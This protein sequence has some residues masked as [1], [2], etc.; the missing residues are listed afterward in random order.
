MATKI[1]NHLCLTS[2]RDNVNV[3]TTPIS[4]CG[5]TFSPLNY[6]GNVLTMYGQAGGDQLIGG[7]GVDVLYGGSGNDYVDDGVHSSTSSYGE[8]YGEDDNDLLFGSVGNATFL[9]GGS[10]NDG[11]RDYGGTADVL[12]GDAGNECCMWDSNDRYNEFDCGTGTD[13][14]RSLS[15]GT[16]AKTRCEQTS[17][18]CGGQAPPDGSCF[19]FQ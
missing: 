7:N 17:S 13:T 18:N 11:V 2:S 1:F 4:A 19:A 5:V 6:N 15:G 14:V 3:V 10:G 12:H 9:S 16:F 8:L